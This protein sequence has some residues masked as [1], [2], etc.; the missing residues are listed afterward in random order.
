MRDDDELEVVEAGERRNEAEHELLD[1]AR[2][3][4]RDELRVDRDAERALAQRSGI[5]SPSSQSNGIRSER[6]SMRYLSGFV[7][8]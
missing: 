3:A 4:A 1:S 2:A 7:L 6:T 5:V 8:S